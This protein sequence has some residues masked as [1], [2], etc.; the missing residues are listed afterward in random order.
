LADAGVMRK[1]RRPPRLEANT[2]SF[3]WI[4]YISRVYEKMATQVPDIESVLV[5]CNS[6]GKY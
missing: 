1:S 4:I 3:P 5:A 2:S 6:H